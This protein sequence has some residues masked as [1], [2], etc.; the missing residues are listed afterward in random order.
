MA[1]LTDAPFIDL[2]FKEFLPR[3]KCVEEFYKAT[4]KQFADPKILRPFILSVEGGLSGATTDLASSNFCPTPLNGKY[5]HTNQG[6]TYGSWT[7]YMGRNRDIAFLKM[8]DRDWMYIFLNG[9]WNVCKASEI[10]SQEVANSLVDYV[11]G[12]GVWGIKYT[13]RLLGV[14][15]DGIIGRITLSAINSQDGRDLANSIND[16]REQ[17]FK[18]IAN[19]IE[20]QQANL[21]GWLNRLNKL[22][23]FNKGMR[24]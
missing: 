20:G 1:K 24:S 21:R 5:Y 14:K 6:I 8:D 16:R 7:H 10:H 3:Y 12:S 22:R 4:K 17:H 9:Y 15:D 19:R 18:S 13:Q 2:E 23:E 11:W